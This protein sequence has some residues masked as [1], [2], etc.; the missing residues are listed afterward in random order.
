[1]RAEKKMPLNGA[2]VDYSEPFKPVAEE[3]WEALR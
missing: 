3:D 1:V 2:L